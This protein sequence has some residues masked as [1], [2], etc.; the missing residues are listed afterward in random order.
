[1]R[2]SYRP[3]MIRRIFQLTGLL[4]AA[5]LAQPSIAN[6]PAKNTPTVAVLYF[7]YD[8]KDEELQALS[9]GFASMLITDMSANSGFEVVERERLQELIGEL[10]LNQSDLA[11]PAKAVQIGKLAGAQRMVVGRYFE[12]MGRFRVDA[13]MFSVETSVQVCGVGV[14]GRRDDFLD[15]EAQIADKLS[16]AMLSDGENCKVPR[17]GAKIVP[18]STNRTM[19]KLSVSTAANYSR[20]LDA[21]DTGKNEEAKEI[22][23]QVVEEEPEFKLAHDE[24][25]RLLK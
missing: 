18:A 8:G 7:D 5:L 3:L 19:S 24:L 1:M 21:I 25:I 15:I 2:S 20:A 16:T 4:V 17:E 12:V 22:L 23:N 9:K 6:T 13:R 14:T 11:D 10:K